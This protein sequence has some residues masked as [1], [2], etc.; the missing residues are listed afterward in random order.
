MPKV[1][2]SHSSADRSAVESKLIRPLATQAIATW[3]STEDIKT[4]SDWETAIRQALT[5][6]DWFLV[7]LTSN[8]I[9][10]LWVKAEVDWAFE[11]REGRVIPVLLE[12]CNWRSLHL[13]LRSVQLVDLVSDE[14]SGQ[15]SLYSMIG[16]NFYRAVALVRSCEE[17]QPE[18]I[19]QRNERWDK[20]V[21]HVTSLP[22]QD[23]VALQIEANERA[24]ARLNLGVGELKQ[25]LYVLGF[26]SGQFDETIDQSLILALTTLQRRSNLRHIDGVFGELTYLAMEEMAR[27][28]RLL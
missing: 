5:E 3:Y 21:D 18:A 24:L 9:A 25:Q 4:A 19:D 12:P 8:S 10:S 28:R 15:R 27:R 20:F 2:V 14:S 22:P 13:L 7:A 11:H 17:V 26:Y 16:S 6:C 1:F 23:R